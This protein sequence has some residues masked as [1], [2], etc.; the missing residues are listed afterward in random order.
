MTIKADGVEFY[1]DKGRIFYKSGLLDTLSI[2]IS[3]DEL[4]Q[5][6][7]IL[8]FRP[9]YCGGIGFMGGALNEPLTILIYPNLNI[10][11][12]TGDFAKYKLIYF[13]RPPF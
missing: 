3:D 13:E 10:G 7:I 5:P 8:T 11:L 4:K 6:E 9:T 12:W 1:D 2:V